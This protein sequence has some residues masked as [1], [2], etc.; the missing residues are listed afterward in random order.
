[1]LLARQSGRAGAAPWNFIVSGTEARY[2]F[3]TT[4]AVIALVDGV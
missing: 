3:G 4:M 2:L 1:L